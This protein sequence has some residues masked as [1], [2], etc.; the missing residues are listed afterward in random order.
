MP[1]FKGSIKRDEKTV[2]I[3]GKEKTKEVTEHYVFKADTYTEAEVILKQKQITHFKIKKIAET[4]LSDVLVDTK[5]NASSWF[6]C[7]VAVDTENDKGVVKKVNSFILVNAIN[8]DIAYQL[9]FD[10]YSSSLA[11]YAIPN[12]DLTNVTDYIQ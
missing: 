5:D 2:D 9:V 7:K 10:F 4:N 11:D 3:K 1:Y 6:K 8:A 12:V